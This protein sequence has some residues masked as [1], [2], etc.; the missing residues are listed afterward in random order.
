[1]IHYGVEQNSLEWYKL[2]LGIPT[3]S[4]FDKILTPKKRERSSQSRHYLFRLVAEW[5]AGEVLED[6]MYQSQWME[7][8]QAKED[9]AI[10]AYEMLAEVETSL[11]GFFT[12]DSGLAGASPDRLVGKEGIVEIKCPLLSKQVEGALNGI[13]ADHVCQ[14]Q[15]QLWVTERRW[16]DIF[17]Y[18]PK[19]VLPPKRVLRD[20]EFIKDLESAV[21]LFVEDMLRARADLEREHGPFLREGVIAPLDGKDFITEED[22][23]EIL[24]MRLNK[25]P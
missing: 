23:D 8:G 14:I 10:A 19:L 4:N 24:R 5:I 12:I 25:P 13:E 17:S 7:R 1:M 20:D 15:G 18:H 16:L 6:E 21:N 9:G 11:G 2:R 3:A 22:L